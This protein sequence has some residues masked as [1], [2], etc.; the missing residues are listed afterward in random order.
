LKPDVLALPESLLNIIP[1]RVPDYERGREHFKIRTSPA[2][3][4]LA[5]AEA[6]AEH[7][8]QFLFNAERATRLV[9]FHSREAKNPGLQEV[10]DAVINATWKSS[11]DSGYLGEISRVVDTVVLYDL[12]SLT[13]NERASP[14]ARAIAGLKLE[15]LKKWAA[16]A[17]NGAKDSEERAHLYF[18]ATQIAQFQKDPKLIPVPTPAKPPDGP[19]IGDDDSA[20]LP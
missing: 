18:A 9:E 7:T 10:L 6:A 3:D 19:P 1:P 12:M 14:Q 2:F 15:E 16:G 4:A 8:L 13:V 11:R 20:W 17:Q 5:P